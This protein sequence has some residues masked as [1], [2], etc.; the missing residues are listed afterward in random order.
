MMIMKMVSV[1]FDLDAENSPTQSSGHNEKWPSRGDN[2]SAGKEKASDG[3]EEVDEI[4]KQRERDKQQLANKSKL[5]KR[6]TRSSGGGADSD[7]SAKVVRASVNEKHVRGDDAERKE[8]GL[9]A[10]EG[11]L[12][13]LDFACYTLSPLTGTFGPFLTLKEH[14]QLLTPAPLVSKH[15]CVCVCVCVCL[16][17]ACVRSASMLA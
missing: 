9:K 12:P 6:N 8:R 5:R 17:H 14:Q 3:S 13:L 10:T 15:E 7:R 11:T 16:M 4:D 2:S 1:A